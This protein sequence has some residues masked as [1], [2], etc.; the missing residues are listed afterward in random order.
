[1]ETYNTPFGEIQVDPE[2][3][4]S[5]PSGL[6][7]LP[8]CKRFKLLH[9][10]KP[11]PQVMWLQSLDDMAVFFN[12]IDSEILGLNYQITLSDEE[13]AEIDM[14]DGDEAKLLLVLRRKEEGSSGIEA[15]TQAPFV[16]NLRTRRALQK[17]GVRADVVFRNV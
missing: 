11:N 9:E 4:I 8:A 14:Q 12:V 16:L 1:M 2:T 15:N 17:T 5:F 7:G 10:D 13:C 3:V 6:P